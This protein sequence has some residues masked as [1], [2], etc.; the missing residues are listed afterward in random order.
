MSDADQSAPAPDSERRLA[1]V[2]ADHFVGA[3][4]AEA[5]GA[6]VVELGEDLPVIEC[7]IDTQQ[8]HP[9]Y[10]VFVFLSIRGGALGGA[11]ALVTASGYGPSPEHALTLAGC[12]WAC[13][14]GPV[15]LT[16]IGRPE[17]INTE[18]PDVELFETTLDGRRHLFAVGHLDRWSD[19]ARAAGAE[20]RRL[21]GPSA[22]TRAVL[23][24]G[25]IPSTRSDGVIALGCFLACGRATSTEVKLGT[26]DWPAAAEVLERLAPP[27]DESAGLHMLREWAILAP[28]EPAPELT[29][30][31]LQRTLDL[32]RACGADPDAEAGWHGAR[33]HGMRLGEPGPADP[34]LPAE[35]NRFITRIAAR[36]AG[37]GYGLEPRRI[38]ERWWHLADAGCGARWLLDRK[39]VV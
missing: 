36:G 32:L 28:L 34:A 6:W 25:T 11:G 31:G 3:R 24:S 1:E 30:E 35:A 9:P 7:R 39:S 13:A 33:H 14:F 20:R 23:T 19:S 29:R 38:D 4:V 17:L 10:G 15:L 18:D 26:A 21:G 12:N 16:G 5:D 2:I 37:P 27:P 22:L 8:D